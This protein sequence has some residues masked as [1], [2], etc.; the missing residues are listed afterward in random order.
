MTLTSSALAAAMAQQ[1]VD[2]LKP[3]TGRRERTRG[4]S[5]TSTHAAK[6]GDEDKIKEIQGELQSER[7]DPRARA[8]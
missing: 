8:S 2:L 4:S 1:E 7:P 6:K 5:A 3:V